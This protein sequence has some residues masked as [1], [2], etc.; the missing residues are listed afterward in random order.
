MVPSPGQYE[1]AVQRAQS[2]TAVARVVDRKR[3]AGHREGEMLPAGQKWPAGH[4]SPMPPNT[5]FTCPAGVLVK[6]AI[7]QK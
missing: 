4:S 1:P 3:P 2:D 7:V 5:V 6:E